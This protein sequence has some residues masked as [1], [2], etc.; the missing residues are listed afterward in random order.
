MSVIIMSVNRRA[1][2]WLERKAIFR[3]RFLVKFVV[4][5]SYKPLFYFA[6]GKKFSQISQAF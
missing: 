5:K 2:G 6:S 4:K 1:G 3:A